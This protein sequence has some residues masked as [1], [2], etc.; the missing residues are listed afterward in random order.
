MVVGSD[1]GPALA[2]WGF[3]QWGQVG[4]VAGTVLLG[5][6]FLFLA[7]RRRLEAAIAFL[8]FAGIAVWLFLHDGPTLAAIT[9]SS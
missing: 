6:G 8:A 5:M 4:L 3:G 9:G 2:G 1:D 7:L